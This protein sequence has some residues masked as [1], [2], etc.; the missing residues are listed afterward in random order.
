MGMTSRE[1]AGGI[2]I[3][4]AAESEFAVMAEFRLA[5]F[6]DMAAA[7]GESSDAV[8]ALRGPNEAWIARHF[9]RDFDEW[10]A[11]AEGEVVASAGVIWFEHPPGPTNPGGTEAYILNVYTRP[12]WRKRGLARTLVDRIVA[13]A[14]S[15]GIRRVWL[16]ASPEGRP[17]YVDM[18]FAE[19]N[20]LQLRE[21]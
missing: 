17:L 5:M 1:R 4:K 21:G 10:L 18:G 6:R 12:D 9:G 19:S 16:R 2:E 11:Q 15:R 14:R 3:R 7:A 8:E 20:Y 13:E